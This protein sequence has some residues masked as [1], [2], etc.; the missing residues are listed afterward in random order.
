MCTLM[1]LKYLGVERTNLDIGLGLVR[2]LHQKLGLS[3][4][5]MLQDAL[6]NAIYAHTCKP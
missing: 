2:D 4:N 1:N 5:H 6:V 3:I